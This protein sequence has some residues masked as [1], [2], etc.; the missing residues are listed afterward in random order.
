VRRAIQSSEENLIALAQRY[1][2]SAAS[3]ATA[4]ADCP[5]STAQRSA[6]KKFKVYPIGYFHV[7]LPEVRTAEGKLY[8]FVA[9]DRTSKF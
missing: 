5:I 6:K 8:L 1:D 4:S 2:R 7:N 9:I 3:S